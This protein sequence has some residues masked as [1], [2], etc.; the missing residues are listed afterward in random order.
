MF[1]GFADTK[2]KGHGYF[3]AEKFLVL[4]PVALAMS[5]L[6][7]IG[8]AFCVTAAP[9][10]AHAYTSPGKPT[11][12]VNDFAGVLGASDR[13]ALEAKLVSLKSRTSDDVV[14]ATVPSLGNETVESYAADLFREWGIGQKGKD[15]GVLILVAPSERQARIEV[16]YGLEGDLTDLQSGNII[17]GVMIPAFRDNEYAKGIGGGVDA[18]SAILTNSPDAA[19]Y[20]QAP[21]DSGANDWSGN[22]PAVF[23]LG[24]VIL[25]ALAR[26]LGRTKSWWLGG[27]IG[28]I[29]GMIVGFGFGFV[30]TGIAAIVVLSLFGLLF[31][32]I[33]SKH[34]PR[35]GGPGGFWPIFLGG[36]RGGSGGGFGGF[37]GGRSGGGGAS[38]GW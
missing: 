35:G 1:R 15:N 4:G 23:A 21:S 28:A 30:P 26:I 24:V 18:V 5:F 38:G 32:Y 8:F 19:Q 9:L 6:F 36:G 31:D 29:V 17:R 16:G 37:G 25:N 10:A 2:K 33:V 22:W 14:V 12:Y 3:S 11:G 34:P 20:S 7:S 13:Q 27:V